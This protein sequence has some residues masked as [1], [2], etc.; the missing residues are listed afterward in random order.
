MKLAIQAAISE[1]QGPRGHEAL[2]PEPAKAALELMDQ[3]KRD[4][5]LG[6]HSLEKSDGEILECIRF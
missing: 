3:I 5:V 6:K 1:A 2:R 4:K